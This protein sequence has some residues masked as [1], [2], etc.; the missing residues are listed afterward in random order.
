MKLDE[1]AS[2]DGVGL[3]E[4]VRDR[5]VT[6]RELGETMLEGI[7]LAN[8]RLNA[9]AGMMHER[10]PNQDAQIAGPFGG[11]PLLIE[12]FPVEAGVPGEMGSQLAVGFVPD[13]DSEV[14]RR[15]KAAGFMS[16]GRTNCS[17]FGLAAVTATRLR[18]RTVNPWDLGRS[19]A[20]SSGGAAAAVSAGVL[21]IAHASDGGGS[22]RNPAS[23]CGLVGLKPSRGR[24]S[25][26]PGS[27]ESMNGLL[28]N[29]GLMRSVRDCAALL[30]ALSGPAA[31]DP[32]FL[33]PPAEPFLRAI[34][35]P[36]P[37][38]RIAL[39]RRVWSGLM[40]DP[41]VSV[42]LTRAG[43]ILQDL[44]HTVEDA[45]PSFD[46]IRFLKAQM[47]IWAAHIATEIDKVA[48]VTGRKI[49]KETL[50]TTTLALY[51]K[52]S[53]VSAGELLAAL[54]DY[55]ATARAVARLF[56]GYDILVTPTC[57]TLPVPIDAHLID[58]PNAL[59]EDLFDHL[60]PIET[61]TAL[62]NCTGQPAISLPV[63]Q[64]S[65]GLPVGM[66]LVA[67]LGAD[68]LLLRLAAQLE[69]VSGWISRKPR[70]HV[71]NPTA[72][73]REN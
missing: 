29:F 24:I 67:R 71:G 44:G 63:S 13:Q 1:Y 40:L 23:F 48:L 25:A 31:G 69:A 9:I 5:Q 39:N 62:F 17:E 46:Y 47:V 61:F 28:V 59:V 30:D 52:G 68:D 12:D 8:G 54:A 36:P 72:F 49:G 34:E 50:M 38:L 26:G 18:G 64:S 58:Q 42:S 55:N 41:K 27:G 21:P 51:Q 60:A 45:V 73:A 2:Y 19:T 22:I 57:A 43:K 15:F 16:L 70:W 7:D 14:I 4:L 20:G 65:V 66:Q 56:A 37:P 3:A 11:V 35:T 33:S 32:Y 10:L 6:A 53:R